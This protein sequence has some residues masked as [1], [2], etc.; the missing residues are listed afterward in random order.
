[1]GRASS[2]RSGRDGSEQAPI[3]GHKSIPAGPAPYPFFSSG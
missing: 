2:F 1:M 3:A